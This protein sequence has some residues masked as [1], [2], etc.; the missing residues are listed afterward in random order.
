MRRA[1]LTS[2]VAFLLVFGANLRGDDFVLERFGDYLEQLRGQF[3]IPGLAAAVIDTQGIAWRR[4]FGKQDVEQSIATRPD[5]PFH[6][7][8]VT[9][10]FTA[11]MVLRCVEEGGLSL[12][13][14]VG[15]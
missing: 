13:D 4:A 9:Q 11:T 1:F 8:A 14:R 12:D 2:I 10:I 7:D 3:G 15:K 5:T 6:V